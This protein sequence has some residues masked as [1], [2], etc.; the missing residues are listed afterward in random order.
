MKVYRTTIQ[1]YKDFDKN[2]I[3]HTDVIVAGEDIHHAQNKLRLHI[4]KKVFN[5]K[6]NFMGNNMD[7]VI[8]DAIGCMKEMLPNEVVTLRSY[9]TTFNTFEKLNGGK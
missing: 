7:E 1:Y 5:Q 9:E 2:T 6:N 8:H 3:V 4:Y